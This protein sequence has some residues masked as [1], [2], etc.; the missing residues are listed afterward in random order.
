MSEQTLVRFLRA[1]PVAM[2]CPNDCGGTV[3]DWLCA[4]K[5]MDDAATYIEQLR[6]E[7]NQWQKGNW[8]IGD[9]ITDKEGET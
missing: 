8:R 9:S 7:L 5:L 2:D 4:E 1:G 6:G 3:A